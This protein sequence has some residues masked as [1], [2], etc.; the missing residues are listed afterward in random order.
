MRLEFSKPI[1]LVLNFWEKFRNSSM[2]N[3]YNFIKHRGK[4]LYTEIEDEMGAK[5]LDLIV[6]GESCPTDVRDIQKS[7]NLADCIEDLRKFDDDTLFPYI[8]ELLEL[9]KEVIKPSAYIW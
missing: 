8:K 3:L 6:N 5:L 7:L 9:I 1:D 2:R 4:P